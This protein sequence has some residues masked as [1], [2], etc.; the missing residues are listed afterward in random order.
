MKKYKIS[1]CII[2]RP[3]EDLKKLMWSLK[4]QTYKPFEIVIHKEI[5]EFPPQGGHF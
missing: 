5:G 1:V 2:S 3:K 4:R